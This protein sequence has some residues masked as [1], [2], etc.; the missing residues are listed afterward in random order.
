MILTINLSPKISQFNCVHIFFHYH[1]CNFLNFFLKLPLRWGAL[2]LCTLHAEFSGSPS[3]ELCLGVGESERCFQLLHPKLRPRRP[4]YQQVQRAGPGFNEQ[5]QAVLGWAGHP[6]ACPGLISV[7]HS[8]TGWLAPGW[9]RAGGKLVATAQGTATANSKGP[10]ARS[11]RGHCGQ[12]T[13]QLTPAPPR[14]GPPG[15]GPGSRAGGARSGPSKSIPEPA[16]DPFESLR[17]GNKTNGNKRRTPS[18]RLVVVE[19][20][21]PP[22]KGVEWRARS[23]PL[24]PFPQFL[25]FALCC[26]Q[27]FSTAF[28][29]LR[30]LCM[31]SAEARAGSDE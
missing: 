27:I 5:T 2:S 6:S 1:L 12:R 23:H 22:G 14:A 20:N 31:S 8:F 24:P 18:P 11:R 7:R 30:M 10:L 26:F 3:R 28:R 16:A 9:R 29:S 13:R 25:N 19:A 15:P 21:L 17:V 4:P